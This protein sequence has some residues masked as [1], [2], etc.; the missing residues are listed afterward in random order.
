MNAEFLDS[1]QKDALQEISNIAMGTA[2]AG[3]ATVLES[4]VRLSVPR[5]SVVETSRIMEGLSASLPLH[6]EVSA[7]RQ[8]FYGEVEGEV[9]VVFGEEGCDELADA[10][11]HENDGRE[12]IKQ[13]LLLDVSNIL[14]GACM[15]GIAR[16][17]GSKIS[18]SPPEILCTA[19]PLERVFFGHKPACE[20]VLLIQ[21][22]F[23][24]EASSFACH[25]LTF[26]AP[27][28]FEV[29]RDSLSRFLES[30]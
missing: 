5:I 6:P 21:I 29:L 18:F 13:E 30:L 22:D 26:L 1:D 2:A 19:V 11:K 3:L 10:L 24:L 14:V 25:V 23:S 17:L 15:N 7:V 12:A 27:A 20:Q 16:Q 28:S 4:F 8:A 9:V